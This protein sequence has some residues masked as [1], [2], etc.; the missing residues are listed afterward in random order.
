MNE[1]SDGELQIFNIL[2][3]KLYSQKISG[4]NFQINLSNFP[5]GEYLIAFV[6]KN[7]FLQF[8]KFV[9]LD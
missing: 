8:S 3:L 1:V 7:Q 2:S 6:H 4:S 9:K 5:Q